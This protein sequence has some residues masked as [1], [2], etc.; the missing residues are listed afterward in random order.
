MIYLLCGWA[1]GAF[2]SRLTRLFRPGMALALQ[3][4]SLKMG[5]ATSSLPHASSVISFGR[6]CVSQ[7]LRPS[8]KEAI[9]T[10]HLLTLWDQRGRGSEHPLMTSHMSSAV[11]TKPCAQAH[12]QRA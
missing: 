9:W 6:R 2:C 7:R 5:K 10:R 3:G 8:A 4:M 12:A 1:V 11:E